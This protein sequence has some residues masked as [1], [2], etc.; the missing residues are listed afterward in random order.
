MG[1][2]YYT[3][4]IWWPAILGTYCVSLISLHIRSN[5][6]VLLLELGQMVS[7]SS[8]VSTIEAPQGSRIKLSKYQ[9]IQTDDGMVHF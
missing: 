5:E 8:T 3:I 7:I 1:L 2:I 4:I 6:A 9:S